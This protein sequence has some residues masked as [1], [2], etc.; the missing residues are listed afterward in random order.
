MV[1]CT[2]APETLEKETFR[3]NKYNKDSMKKI[4]I[5]GLVTLMFTSCAS[6][7]NEQFATGEQSNCLKEANLS[8]K[9]KVDEQTSV[10]LFQTS[11]KPEI[12]HKEGWIH[13]AAR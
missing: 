4:M 11:Y 9:G 13:P 6:T 7:K 3:I 8:M 10:T 1:I 5:S 2:F 12:R